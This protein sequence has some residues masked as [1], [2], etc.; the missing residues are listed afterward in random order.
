MLSGLLGKD[1][2]TNWY[3]CGKAGCTHSSIN[4]QNVVSHIQARHLH[5]FP[6]LTCPHCHKVSPT[7]NAQSQHIKRM[8]KDPAK[9][10]NAADFYNI[11]IT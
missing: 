4:R 5:N 11:S 2:L 3:K 8:H 1:P 6:G 10:M 9:M 7:V